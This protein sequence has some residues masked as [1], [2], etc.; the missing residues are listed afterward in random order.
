MIKL[1]IEEARQIS[2]KCTPWETLAQPFEPDLT[3]DWLNKIFQPLKETIPSLL[4]DL[5]KSEK[6]HWD[7]S[8]QSQQNLCSKLLDEFGRD[9]DLVVV[10]KS[11]HPFSITLGP[12]DYRITTRV[13]EL[14]LIH[15]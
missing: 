4:S 2:A 1:R 10:A 15:I 11:P 6:H 3:I 9:E 5:D 7:L 14:S 12:E 13:V 8:P